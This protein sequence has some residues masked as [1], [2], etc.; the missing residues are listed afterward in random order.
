MKILFH[1]VVLDTNIKKRLI[2]IIKQKYTL[3]DLDMINEQVLNS[4]SFQ[5]N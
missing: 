2:D 4:D 1:L 3:I 5:K